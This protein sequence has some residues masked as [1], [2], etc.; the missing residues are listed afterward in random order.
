MSHW[1]QQERHA[2][3]VTHLLGFH[4]LSAEFCKIVYIIIT[5]HSECRQSGKLGSNQVN[6]IH[7][8]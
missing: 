5:I 4:R 7:Y 1:R 2:T 8:Y 6:N 3:Y